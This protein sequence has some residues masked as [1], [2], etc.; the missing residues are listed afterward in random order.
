MVKYLGLDNFLKLI[1]GM[2]VSHSMRE[3]T[4]NELKEI[5][6]LIDKNNTKIEKQIGFGVPH[7]YK[8]EVITT[9]NFSS[10]KSRDLVILLHNDTHYILVIEEVVNNGNTIG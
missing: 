10:L 2:E 6:E 4:E 3:I 5:F 1:K 7:S 9:G 8:S